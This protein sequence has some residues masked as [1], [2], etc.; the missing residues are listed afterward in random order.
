MRYLKVLALILLFVVSILFFSQNNEILA[1]SLVLRLDVPYI[2]ELRSVP[3]PFYFLVLGGFVVGAVLTMLYFLSEKLKAAKK[4][5][6]CNSRMASLEQE[7]NS[8]R[9]MPLNEEP[10]GASSDSDSQ[11]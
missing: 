1:Q 11:S 2:A 5:R 8:L 6:E 7:L 4:L 9:N 3:L 10:V